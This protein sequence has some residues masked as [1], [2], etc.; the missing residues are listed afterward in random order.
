MEKYLVA[1]DN[2]SYL[3]KVLAYVSN[4]LQGKKE[5]QV[6]LLHIK[7]SCITI[8]DIL[9]EE[10]DRDLLIQKIEELKRNKRLCKE[11]REKI[12]NKIIEKAMKAFTEKGIDSKQIFI[13]IVE[14]SGDYA[15]MIIDKAREH[16]CKT[17]VLG[18]K[19]DSIISEYLI[20]STAEKV[21]RFSKGVTVWLVD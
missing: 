14:E 11:S 13:D 20:G 8:D 4:Q 3:D 21:S 6:I 19:G 2:S 12:A 7:Q 18:K 1:I 17:I 9:N 15:T 5:F 16:G 10:F